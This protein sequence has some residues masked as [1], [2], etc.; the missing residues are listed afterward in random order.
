MEKVACN[1]QENSTNHAKASQARVDPGVPP[2]LTWHRKL[3]W[4]GKPL[5]SFSL[6]KLE[7]LT[8]AP[9]GY[10]FWRYVK[11]EES[12]GRKPINDFFHPPKILPCQGVPLGGIGAGS[13][14]RN[15]KGEFQRWQLFP[16]EWQEDPV[17]ANQFSVFCSRSNGQK[18]SSVLCPGCP[19]A[20]K[21]SSD[22]GIRSWD[23]KLDGKNCTYHAL[24]P[25]AWT[26]YDGEPDPELKIV[27]RQISPFIPHNYKES[28]FPVSVF[29][30][31]L[32]N[33]GSTAVDVNLLFT[34][35]NSVGGSSELSGG[36]SNSI[37]TKK[38]GVQGVLLNHKTAN[39]Q[40]PITFAIA[41]QETEDVHVSECP[42]FIVSGNGRGLSA[43]KMWCHIKEHGS[44]DQ[45]VPDGNILPSEK[46][47]SIGAAVL[48]SVTVPSYQ[49]RTVTFSLAW[50]CPELRFASGKTYHRRYTKF[51][52]FNGDAAADLAHDAI[53]G[54]QEWE[55]QIEMWQHPIL[56]DKR[57]PDWYP[58][59]LFNE[60][61]YLNAGGTIWTDGMPCIQ[62]KFSTIDEKVSSNKTTSQSKNIDTSVI[63]LD[64]I[65]TALDKTRSS[66]ASNAAFGPTFL[67]E[68]EENV[69]QFLYL[70]GIEYLMWNTYDVH[71]YASYA[72]IMTFPK[73]ELSI[74]RDFAAAIMMDDQGKVY[75]IVDGKWATRKV[76][77]AVPHD[78]GLHD[79]WFEV[80]AYILHGTSKWKDLNPKFV[81]QVYRDFIATGDMAFCRAVWPSVYVAMAYMEQFDKDEDGMIENEGIPDQTYD[82]WSVTGV[83]AYTGGLWVAAL[84]AASAMAHEVGDKISEDMFW[85][86]YEKAKKVYNTLWNGSYLNYDNS[87]GP[88]SSS[89]LADQL[90][91]HWYARACGLAP[92]LDEEKVHTALEK[93]YNFNVLQFKDGK[94]GAV[95]GMLPN[96][97]VDTTAMMSKEVWPGVTYGLAATM[98]QEGMEEIAFKT[99]RGVYEAVWSQEG[100][101]C[102]FQTPEGWTCDEKYRSI[103]YMRPLAIWAMHWA[104][105][106]PKHVKEVLT[107][108][109]SEDDMIK[110]HIGYKNVSEILKLPKEKSRSF[111]HILYDH[112][113][114]RWWT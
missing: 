103:S 68:G 43:E 52:G 99:A 16:A 9:I 70:E 66:S 79:P 81:L 114:R 60:L 20:V 15:Y 36:H 45:H 24:F 100:L 106:P 107:S 29:T 61:Y 63:V 28:S 25:R 48:S 58:V 109:K 93:I 73:L 75:T 47:S 41:S 18:F 27:C 92:V 94:W 97:R 110:H 46:G 4:E 13:I 1:G 62:N 19:D 108:R 10:R 56:Q 78:I 59:T 49:A 88:T 23:W 83:S 64:R 17:L 113:C 90:S 33:S 76:I 111:L 104:L 65:T 30:F 57:L 72:L 86:K 53:M 21:E 82:L 85:A 98:I 26:V 105:S 37:F 89:I 50:A 2:S 95:N 11:E 5:S 55:S 31:E 6:T 42:C 71:F 112:T 102:A 3:N 32:T 80:N 67:E 54:H 101:G 74:Q 22:S 7:M 14:G 91:G 34:W 44:F 39:G 35:T 51:Y 87:D 96:G 40:S 77:G 38:H 8:M 69:G 84:E 12:K